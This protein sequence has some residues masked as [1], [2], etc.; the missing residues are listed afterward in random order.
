MSIQLL[1]KVCIDVLIHGK[2]RETQYDTVNQLFTKSVKHSQILLS[3]T[4]FNQS[5]I[6]TIQT[7]IHLYIQPIQHPRHS[8][9]DTVSIFNT[10][11]KHVYNF[12]NPLVQ[13]CPLLTLKLVK[14]LE[15]KI[16]HIQRVMV[17]VSHH[18]QASGQNVN[19]SSLQV[20]DSH[21]QP[22]VTTSCTIHIKIKNIRISTD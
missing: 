16:P 21:V 15:V 19:T 10:H 7:I 5:N 17:T 9:H 4:T 22:E 13:A 3:I 14:N 20:T 1:M 2:D 11:S 6:H 8:N 12:A 18:P